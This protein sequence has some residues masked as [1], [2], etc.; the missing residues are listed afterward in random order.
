MVP[1]I[2]LLDFDNCYLYLREILNLGLRLMMNP[3]EVYIIIE[4]S[5]FTNPTEVYIIIE[6]SGFTNP[7]EVYIIIEVSG[8]AFVQR[9]LRWLIQGIVWLGLNVEFV[10]RTGFWNNGRWLFFR[11]G[12]LGLRLELVPHK[13]RVRMEHWVIVVFVRS[14]FLLAVFIAILE[15]VVNHLLL[16]RRWLQIRT[17]LTSE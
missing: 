11:K 10:V 12:M 6:V 15:E 16:A 17:H 14:A 7:T 9:G 4:V 3:T 13:V 5:G 2:E 8:F 1:S